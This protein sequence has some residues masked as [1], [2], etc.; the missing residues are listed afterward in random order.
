MGLTKVTSSKEISWRA[1]AAQP[2]R[3]LLAVTVNFSRF[4]SRPVGPLEEKFMCSEQASASF[5]RFPLSKNEKKKRKGTIPLPRPATRPP[6]LIWLAADGKHRSQV[7]NHHAL[8]FTT[9]RTSMHLLGPLPRRSALLWA[10][11][12]ITAALLEQPQNI[13]QKDYQIY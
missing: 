9:T 11:A 1:G 10:M 13:G 12:Q 2:N 6:H 5:S 4:W 3:V 8:S 7:P